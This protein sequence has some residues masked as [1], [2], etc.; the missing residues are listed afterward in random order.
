VK[1][2]KDGYL[3]PEFINGNYMGRW[4]CRVLT[5]TE[6]FNN[7]LAYL[8]STFMGSV[9]TSHQPTS[10]VLGIKIPQ[11]TPE[12]IP[13]GELVFVLLNGKVLGGLSVLSEGLL[14]SFDKM[15][16]IS[17]VPYLIAETAEDAERLKD[18]SSNE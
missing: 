9:Y 16:C 7:S 18:W 4:V 13:V 5:K 12:D 14:K 15:D 8:L 11:F 6:L 17:F 10:D 1:I 2:F 3:L